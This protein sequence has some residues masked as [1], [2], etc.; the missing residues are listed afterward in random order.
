MNLLRPAPTRQVNPRQSR[1]AMLLVVGALAWMR[2]AAVF[3]TEIAVVDDAGT[4]LTLTQPARRIVSLSPHLTEL[5]Y[6]AG[7]GDRLVGVSRYSDHPA[8]A[9]ALPVL[10]DAFT[11]NLEAIRAARPD[12]VLVWQSGTAQRSRDALKAMAQ[13]EG[14]A[15]WEGESRDVEGIASTLER[16]GRLSGTSATANAEAA[17]QRAAWA[18]LV[19]RWQGAAPVRV[20]YQVW[21][22]PLMTFNREHGVSRALAACG[23]VNGFGHLA[24]LTPTVSREA[25]LAFDPQLILSGSDDPQRAL[26]AWRALPRISAVRNGQ[27]KGVPGDVLTRMGPRFVGA[28]GQLCD[29]V[30]AARATAK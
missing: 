24:S 11:L 29:L 20:F 10:S 17:A 2:P 14:F 1:I 22:A 15:V 13:R 5:V 28:A 19:A 27:L 25:V 21:D 9:R 6:A 8:A 18:A 26:A 30:D 16:I 12:L 4:R 7:A 23:A 3:S